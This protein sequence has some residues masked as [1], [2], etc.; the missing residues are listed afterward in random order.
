[1]CQAT[2]TLIAFQPEYPHGTTRLCGAHNHTCAITFSIHIL[3]AYKIAVGGAKVE[4]GP[5]AS[6][7]IGMG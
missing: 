2:G 1:M 5:S 6:E 4:S 7:G 3:D